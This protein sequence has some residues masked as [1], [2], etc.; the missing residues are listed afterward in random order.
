[1]RHNA[2]GPTNNCPV[3]S[4]IL[5]KISKIVATICQILGLKCSL[6]NSLSAGAQPQTPLGELTA[7]PQ[8]L[9][10]FKG[11]TAKGRERK[12]RVGGGEEKV[13]RRERER[14]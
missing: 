1:V 3:C 8:T 9:A 4:L 13:K 6:S 5:R 7:I 12:G 10:V 11:L 14:R 2:F